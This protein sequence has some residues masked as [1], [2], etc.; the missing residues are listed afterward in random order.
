MIKILLVDDRDIFRDSMATLLETEGDLEVIGQA[1]N[2]NTAIILAGELKPDII[3]MDIEMPVCNGIIA[4]R[5]ICKRYPK[6]GI[7]MLTIFHDDEY[8][9][10]SLQAGAKDFILK[11]TPVEKIASKI[12][13]VYT[14]VPNL[15]T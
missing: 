3:L 14:A 2:G 5:E 1:N 8:L 9:K 11:R 4:T 10:L 6:I 12:R 15:M 13:N 7:L